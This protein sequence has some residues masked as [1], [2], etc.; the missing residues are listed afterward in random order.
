MEIGKKTTELLE[1]V[2]LDSYEYILQYK[3]KNKQFLQRQ[4]L[5]LSKLTATDKK[6][7]ENE[8]KMYNT[9]SSSS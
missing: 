2:F 3:E 9:F 4:N 7:I 1:Q 8:N 5:S 6:K